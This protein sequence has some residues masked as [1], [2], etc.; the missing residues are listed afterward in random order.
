MKIG[1]PLYKMKYSPFLKE[2][3]M[4]NKSKAIGVRVP[5]DVYDDISNYFKGVYGDNYM[6][7]GIND[8]LIGC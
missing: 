1:R 8:I 7:K 4:K 3:N 5:E 6:S 2:R